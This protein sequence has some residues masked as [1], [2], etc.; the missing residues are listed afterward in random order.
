MFYGNLILYKYDKSHPTLVK[1]FVS[2]YPNPGN[3]KKLISIKY[4][5]INP[6]TE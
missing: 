4:F 3:N 2:K 5:K 6:F 1:E